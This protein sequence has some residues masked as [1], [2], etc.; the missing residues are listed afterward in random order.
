[1]V[2]AIDPKQVRAL[3]ERLIAVRSVS[4]DPEAERACAAVIRGSLPPGIESGEWPTRD[5]RPVVWAMARGRSRRAVLMLGHYDTVG[6]SEFASLGDPRGEAVAFDPVALRTRLLELAARAPESA[7]DARDD[8]E[9]ERRVPGSW[10]FGRGALD[11]KSGIAAGIAA[12]KALLV[13]REALAGSI[14]FVACPDEEVQ[15]AGMLAALPELVRA[16]DAAALELTGVLNLDFAE[17]PSVHAGVVGKLRVG[18]W[19]LGRPTHVGDPLRGT[20]AAQLAAAIA[21]HATLSTDLVERHEEAATPTPSLLRLRDLKSGYDAQTAPEAELELNVLTYGRPIG[22]VLEGVRALAIVAGDELVRARADLRAARGAPGAGEERPRVLL[23]PELVAAA[24]APA[25]DEPKRTPSADLAEV[26]RER[27]RRLARA[28]RL[29]GPAVVI[30]LLPPFYPAAAPGGGPLVAASRRVAE[31]DG[32]ARRGRYPHISD[33]SYAAW[34]GPPEEELARYLPAL[35]REYA[36]PIGSAAALGLEVVNVG[37]WGR[38]AHGL[39]ERVRAD[40]AFERL[41]RR[42]VDVAREAL[43]GG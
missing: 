41:P 39:F 1:M 10:L 8:L 13:D 15:S 32:L 20:D 9:E 34:P 11:M 38:G 7:G 28:A 19:V 24:D 43:R 31:R 17:E 30:T 4:P 42:I 35:G 33:L 12:L 22:E 18:L 2:I 25:A 21:R 6:V 36:L 16:R 23:Y 29:P 27:V 3:T 40:D 14:L 26:T 5:G 37:P